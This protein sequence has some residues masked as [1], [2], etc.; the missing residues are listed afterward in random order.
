L[1]LGSEGCGIATT[2]LN[3]GIRE[4]KQCPEFEGIPAQRIFSGKNQHQPHTV[5]FCGANRDGGIRWSARIVNSCRPDAVNAAILQRCSKA[6]DGRCEDSTKPKTQTS[7]TPAPPTPGK[8]KA[9][10]NCCPPLSYF[11]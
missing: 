9:A 3:T 1:I 6:T 5:S 4:Q 11:D 10:G 8:T 7:D 2:S